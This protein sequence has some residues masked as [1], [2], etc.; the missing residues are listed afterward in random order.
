MEEY[1]PFARTVLQITVPNLTEQ[2]NHS[3][4]T[5]ET[6]IQNQDEPYGFTS[7]APSMSFPN[8]KQNGY[9]RNVNN[10]ECNETGSLEELLQEWGL[11]ELK[12]YF[13]RKLRINTFIV[14]N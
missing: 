4:V 3:S 6:Y 9:Q 11:D 5:S 2:E 12:S 10:V 8:D 14:Q 1:D 7:M 13:I